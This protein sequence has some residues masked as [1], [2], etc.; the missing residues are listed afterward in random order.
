M[1]VKALVFKKQDRIITSG[2]GF[3]EALRILGVARKHDVPAGRVRV[4]CFN[5]LRMKRTAFDAAA[6]RHPD[7]KSIRPRSVAA[8]P[9]SRDFIP[10]LHESRPGIIRELNLDN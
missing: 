5:A 10:H 4:H 2:G 7:N 6:A 8:P 1:P 3:D 9:E